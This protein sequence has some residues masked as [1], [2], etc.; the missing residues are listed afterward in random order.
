MIIIG[1]V[2][3]GIIFVTVSYFMRGQPE[4]DELL[5]RTTTER[6]DAIVGQEI[7][8]AL[9]QIETLKLSRDIFE[10][11]VFLRL[12]DKSQP[13][14]PEAVGK[15]NPFDPITGA[16]APAART[17]VPEIRETPTGQGSIIRSTTPQPVI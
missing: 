13:I 1:V 16:N 17:T 8:T 5:Q 14:P 9:N 3:L 6:P 7:I 12:R 11:P 10:N 4:E 2:V 15:P